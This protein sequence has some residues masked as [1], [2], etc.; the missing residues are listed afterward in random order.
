ML[1]PSSPGATPQSWSNACIFS[2]VTLNVWVST[3]LSLESSQNVQF[4]FGSLLLLLS[5]TVPMVRLNFLRSRGMHLEKNLRNLLGVLL[6]SVIAVLPL[7]LRRAAVR[8][9]KFAAKQSAPANLSA[10]VQSADSPDSSE[11]IRVLLARSCLAM[12]QLTFRLCKPR[13]RSWMLTKQQ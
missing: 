1:L 9:A 4:G 8:L 5:A 2:A 13:S 10:D 11:Q 7:E 12:G 6:G 3:W